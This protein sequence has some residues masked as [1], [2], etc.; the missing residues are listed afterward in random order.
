MGIPIFTVN[1]GMGSYLRDIHMTPGR[2]GRVP[3]IKSYKNSKESYKNSK[4]SYKN[5]KESYKNSKE[6]YKKQ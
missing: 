3:S 6:S 5:S 4:E 1:M 2:H